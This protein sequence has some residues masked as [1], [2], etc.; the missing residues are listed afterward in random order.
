MVVRAFSCRNISNISVDNNNPNYLSIDGNLYYK[1]KNYYYKNIYY[2]NAISLIQYA[3][4]KTPKSFL[5][6]DYVINIGD[7]AFDNCSALTDV[8]I[9]NSV[10]SIGRYAFYHCDNLKSITIPNSVESIGEGAFQECKSLT[11][12]TI[13]NSVTSISNSAFLYTAEDFTIIGY[14]GS[15]AETFANNYGYTFVMINEPSNY[16]YQM[17]SDGTVEITGYTGN[18]DK[19][20]IPSEFNG[21]TVTSISNS[22]FVNCKKLTAVTIPN[23]VKNISDSAFKDCSFLTSVDIPN[24]VTV[25]GDY[26]FS[27][28]VSLSNIRVDKNNTAYCSIDGNLYNK[29]PATILIQYAIGKT[30]AS[31]LSPTLSLVL[32]AERFPN[33]IIWSL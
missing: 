8:T 16:T 11:D 20:S 10:I 6:P 5:I 7:R 31:L 27:G 26:V 15:A 19:I 17:L 25:I 2:K 3:I 21:L 12:I 30:S 32:A 1:Y 28:C 22:A 18:G 33:A 23:S 24:S 13:P 4:G 14:E 29:K 9:P